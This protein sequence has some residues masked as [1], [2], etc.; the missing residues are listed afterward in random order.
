[1]TSPN[2]NDTEWGLGFVD[3]FRPLGFFKEYQHLSSSHLAAVLIEM[4]RLE[5]GDNFD[6]C[7][8]LA[9]LFLLKF[10]ED[11]VWW[12]DTEADVC[13]ENQ[14][15]RKTLEEWSRISLGAFLPTEIQEKWQGQAGPV[16]ISLKLNKLPVTL[17]PRYMDDYLDIGILAGINAAIRQTDI[18]FAVHEIF[19]QTAFILALAMD[20]KRRLQEERG[21]RFA[22]V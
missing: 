22:K 12:D 15:Y 5:M 13:S 16:E 19:D 20:D 17:H 7:D 11:R 1:M 14:V 21:W 2:L 18:Q 10:D 4:L 8:P 6:P 9:D 3:F